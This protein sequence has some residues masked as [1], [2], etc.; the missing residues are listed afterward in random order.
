MPMEVTTPEI[1]HM[2]EINNVYLINKSLYWNSWGSNYAY[3]EF[4]AKIIVSS[5]EQDK[6]TQEA[7][8]S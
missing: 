5:S 7:C 8:N 3:A 4:G 6:Q 1:A 2:T